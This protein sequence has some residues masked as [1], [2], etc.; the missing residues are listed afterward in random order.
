MFIFQFF[1]HRQQFG[2]PDDPIFHA[3]IVKKKIAFNGNSY[4]SQQN[5]FPYLHFDKLLSIVFSRLGHMPGETESELP[6]MSFRI[7]P[8]LAIADAYEGNNFLQFAQNIDGT[9]ADFPWFPAPKIVVCSAQNESPRKICFG[10]VTVSE[11]FCSQ[12]IFKKLL[13]KSGANNEAQTM[14]QNRDNPI[15]F[16]NE[17]FKKFLN[18]RATKFSLLVPVI[19][20]WIGKVALVITCFKLVLAV[21]AKARDVVSMFRIRFERPCL[22]KIDALNG[23][24]AYRTKGEVPNDILFVNRLLIA[25][26]LTLT[27]DFLV[28]RSFLAGIAFKIFTGQWKDFSRFDLDL[29]HTNQPLLANRFFPFYS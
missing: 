6:P 16:V 8:K 26:K 28:I 29:F 18:L 10:S 14:R 22:K 15:E 12:A 24:A 4:S 1:S 17:Q 13:C 2:F 19:T 21:T 7:P 25:K 27:G 5:F 11:L 20:L 23:K 9:I 3:Q